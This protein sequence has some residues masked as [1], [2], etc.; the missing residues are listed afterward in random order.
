MAEPTQNHLLCCRVFPF[1]YSIAIERNVS[2]LGEMVCYST[3]RTET[4]LLNLRCHGTVI[5][6]IVLNMQVATQNEFWDN[7]KRNHGILEF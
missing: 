7:F 5:V 1:N 2:H 3:S 4:D 6:K